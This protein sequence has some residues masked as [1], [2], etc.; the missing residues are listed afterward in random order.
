M[1]DRALRDSVRR[2]AGNRCEYCHLRQ[3]HVESNH[4]VEHIIP[5]KHGGSDEIANLA[6]AC[7]RC[8][9]RKG[10]NLSG[11]DPRS[12]SVMPL[13]HPRKDSWSEHFRVDSARIRG[14]TAIGRATV[15]TL[16]MNEARRVELRLELL[17][18][19][20]WE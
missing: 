10:T 6:L 14:L 19:G 3:E 20:D 13:F 8:N 2:R 9:L 5:R 7:D 4:H 11:V 15:E 18:T 17:A 1:I 12:G 16:G